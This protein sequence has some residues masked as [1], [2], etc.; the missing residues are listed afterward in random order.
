MS[1]QRHLASV[2]VDGGGGWMVVGERV[3][4]MAVVD[5]GGWWMVDGG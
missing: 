2:V 5:G 3:G 4:G 1:V